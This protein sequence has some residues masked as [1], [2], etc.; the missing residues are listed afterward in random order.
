M[1]V[2]AYRSGTLAADRHIHARNMVVGSCTKIIRHE[3]GTLAGAAGS[4]TACT[5]FLNWVKIMGRESFSNDCPCWEHE[6]SG[7]SSG[8]IVLAD[9]RMRLYDLKSGAYEEVEAPYFAIGD[10]AELAL[11]AMATGATAAEAVRAACEHSVWCGGGCDVLHHRAAEIYDA[12]TTRE[13][14]VGGY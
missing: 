9:G 4:S 11:G 2:I 13:H 1:T 14:R 10:G 8:M 12:F 5:G 6:E 3:D 7:T